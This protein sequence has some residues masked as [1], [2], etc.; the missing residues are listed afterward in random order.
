MTGRVVLAAN[1]NS[2]LLVNGLDTAVNIRRIERYLTLGWQSGAI[3]AVVLTKSDCRT[4][5]EVAD[6]V[7]LVRSVALGVEIHTVSAAWWTG[8]SA[9]LSEAVKA[10]NSLNLEGAT[11]HTLSELATSVINLEAEE[12]YRVAA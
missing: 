7:E 3:P 5:D 4:D 8:S 11:D 2:V 10:I 9:M 6:A 1:V 12:E